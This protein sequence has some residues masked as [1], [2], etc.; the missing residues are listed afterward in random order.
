MKYIFTAI[1]FI[2]AIIAFMFF[3]SFFMGHEK[4]DHTNQIL[5]LYSL[6]S[7]IWSGGFSMLFIQVDFEKGYLWR[8]FAIFGTILYMVTVQIL[9]C[10]ISG[11][12]RKL[13]YILNLIS[14]LGF[15]IYFLAIQRDQTSYIMSP[16]GMTCQF[17]PGI[18]SS[19]YTFY[20]IIVTFNIFC[21][22][23][24]M[25]RFSKLKR[26]QNFGKMFL[27][28]AILITLGSILDMFFPFLGFPALPGSNLTQFWGLLIIQYA[29]S[30]V[31]KN[32]INVSNMSEFIYYSLAMPVLVFDSDYKIKIANE[33]AA[34]FFYL[35]DILP[36]DTS[37]SINYFFPIGNNECFDF[38]G[39]KNSIDSVCSTNNIPCNLAISKIYDNFDDTTGYIIIVSDHLERVRYIEE[40]QAAK[41]EADSSNQ[42]KSLFLA[43]MSHEIRT[44]MNAIIG[45]SELAIKES[46][47]PTIMEYLNDI[48]TASHHLLEL[49]N[50]ILDISKIESGKM[51]IIRANYETS[52][53]FHD[54]AQIIS[55]QASKK[56]LDFSMHID[57]A[58]PK[59]LYGDANHMRSV[60]I[61]LLNNAVKYTSEGSVTLDADCILVEGNNIT[62]S[63]SVADTGIGIRPQEMDK[64]FKNFS[65]INQSSSYMTEGT[66]LGLALVKNLCQIMGGDVAVESEY[67]VGS[68]FTATLKQVIVDATPITLQTVSET[69]TDDFSLGNL[70]L[71]DVHALVVDDNAVNLKVISTSLKYYGISV[72]TADS[73]AY[74]IEK[75][76]QKHYSLIFMDQMM[77]EMDGIEAMQHIRKLSDYYAPG[78]EA[79]I[80]ALTA[81]AVAGVKE[82][83]LGLGFDAFLSKPINYK[84]LE[85]TF[86]R[87]VPSD[88]IYFGSELMEPQIQ[89]E[90]E[91]LTENAKLRALLPH[92]DTKDGLMHCGG[93]LKDYL[94]ILKLLYNSAEDQLADLASFQNN[95]NAKDFAILAHALKG[96]CL[97][98]GAS[99]VALLAKEL[100]FAG[101]E[102]DF[103]FIDLHTSIF[104][105][106]FRSLLGEISC[107]LIEFGTIQPMERAA[108]KASSAV[109]S[110]A[111]ETLEKQAEENLEEIHQAIIDMDFA[112]AASLC[113][114]QLRTEY[115]EKYADAFEQV[116]HM[117]SEM[118]T[119]GIE[120]LIL[121][122]KNEEDIK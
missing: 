100:E 23:V 1:L 85:E 51:E 4:K 54:V 37:L 103:D 18:V 32:K 9:I 34:R 101:K 44:P 60:L 14:C 110:N 79:K 61:N 20:F 78:G 64:L 15:I 33:A 113:R 5:C 94:E 98:I 47:S 112:H 21:V 3:L 8:S 111:K 84:E 95:K 65:Q 58:M 13:R 50:D 69:V 42:A 68:T 102:E 117:L 36:D 76:R 53:L 107:A 121:S 75:C 119:D 87:Y 104:I 38:E 90:E 7:C 41:K 29:M 56:G 120:A 88:C 99:S 118:D 93:D 45:F 28:V 86:K 72:E 89:S 97:N 52:N 24:Y 106:R 46:P 43:K 40:L 66:G 57:P 6:S 83:L 67:G 71:H 10:E 116:D 77:P 62:L 17:T 108:F 11:L 2:N 74:A 73:G 92:V 48:K 70:K 16:F 109:S 22:I 26:T 115:P 63:L 81:N 59:T 31:N 96:S 25:I 27:I 91:K 35:P 122:L 30:I 80:I 55:N 12:S 82:E 114:K 105:D 19:L 39:D 49:I